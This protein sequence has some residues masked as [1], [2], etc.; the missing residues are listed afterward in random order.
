V[1]GKKELVLAPVTIGQ[2][3][4]PTGEKAIKR[5]E[6]I[7]F[8][9]WDGRYLNRDKKGR[10]DVLFFNHKRALVTEGSYS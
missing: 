2:T 5:G 3:H 7:A 1:P 10:G 8:L 9:R 4:L 6:V